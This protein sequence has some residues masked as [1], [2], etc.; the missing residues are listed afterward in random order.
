MRMNRLVF[1]ALV[2]SSFDE[3]FKYCMAFWEVR[4][5][6]LVYTVDTNV[7]LSRAF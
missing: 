6:V 5:Y 7:Q 3:R 4:P 2:A 1:H